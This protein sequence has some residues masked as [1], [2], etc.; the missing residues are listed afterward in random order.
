LGQ[1]TKEGTSILGTPNPLPSF[2]QSQIQPPNKHSTNPIRRTCASNS[3][4]R[5]WLTKEVIGDVQFQRKVVKDPKWVASVQI[6]KRNLYFLI[7]G[8]RWQG[9]TT[10]FWLPG[11]VSCKVPGFFFWAKKKPKVHIAN[12]GVT[13]PF[14]N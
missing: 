7:P 6:P 5:K 10:K 1:G 11:M 14:R 3:K 13:C 12:N 9:S 2:C 8:L 4:Q